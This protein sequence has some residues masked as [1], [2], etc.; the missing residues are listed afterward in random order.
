MY[1]WKFAT[2]YYAM[3][4]C[5]CACRAREERVA[6]DLERRQQE[7]AECIL[8]NYRSLV[9]KFREKEIL[10]TD[11]DKKKHDIQRL[12]AIVA[13]TQNK[14][15]ELPV[16]SLVELVRECLLFFTVGNGHDVYRLTWVTTH[17]ASGLVSNTQGASLY[18]QANA[19]S[20]FL[21]TLQNMCYFVAINLFWA[22]DTWNQHISFRKKK[23]RAIQYPDG[24]SLND[25]YYNVK[26]SLNGILS[27]LADSSNSKTQTAH[28]QLPLFPGVVSMILR[29]KTFAGVMKNYVRSI[30]MSDTSRDSCLEQQFMLCAEQYLA[31]IANNEAESATSSLNCCAHI[32]FC[33]PWDRDTLFKTVH[34][35]AANENTLP[36]LLSNLSQSDAGATSPQKMCYEVNSLDKKRLKTNNFEPTFELLTAPYVLVNIALLMSNFSASE[37][38]IPPSVPGKLLKLCGAF[39]NLIPYDI[40]VLRNS[41]GSQDSPKDMGMADSD[42]DSDESVDL[43]MDDEAA[44]G[45]DPRLSLLTSIRNKVRGVSNHELSVDD[46]VALWRTNPSLIEALKDTWHRLIQGD[47]LGSFLSALVFDRYCVSDSNCQSMLECST[48]L[49]SSILL[50]LY[51]LDLPLPS[52][53]QDDIGTS[54]SSLNRARLPSSYTSKFLRATIL[55]KDVKDRTQKL[56]HLLQRVCHRDGSQGLTDNFS[57]TYVFTNVLNQMLFVVTDVDF[58]EYSNP[59]GKEEVQQLVSF[60]SHRLRR[61][62]CSSVQLDGFDL[63]SLLL[64]QQCIEAYK[65]LYERH[66]RRP[67][68]YTNEQDWLWNDM[69][70]PVNGDRNAATDLVDS[71]DA[72]SNQEGSHSFFSVANST[73][74]NSATVTMKFVLLHVP[75]VV[76]FN[77]RAK[78]FEAFLSRNKVSVIYGLPVDDLVFF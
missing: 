3:L 56:W 11:F 38:S 19:D 58:F 21:V 5:V 4:L 77:E 61:F 78:L 68:V 63:P 1:A 23:T 34:S 15:F 10:R 40:L 74:H 59:F 75:M 27:V 67:E 39:V 36:S 69:I 76:P 53:V 64:G 54:S 12:Q 37:Q 49:I 62:C 44:A 13:S 28:F 2:V 60:Y 7:A 32:I 51:P 65:R 18:H 33:I 73:S 72:G 71:V 45:S 66:V 9:T 55:R 16:K 26:C 20:S 41:S 50:K 42:S 22:A 48:E 43:F 30:V 52:S 57:M 35:M 47:T 17:L 25:I 14:Q 29:S 8:H 46:A 6:R 31:I 70:L 24:V